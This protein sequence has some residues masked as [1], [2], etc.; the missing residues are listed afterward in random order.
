MASAA[1]RFT[2]AVVGRTPRNDRLQKYCQIE[3]CHG[4]FEF[5]DRK[6]F[7]KKQNLVAPIL[8]CIYMG[9]G[10]WTFFLLCK[11]AFFVLLMR[12]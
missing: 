3:L 10:Y 7:V 6:K 4:G 9:T 5:N 12:D 2:V 11:V 8:T 1:T